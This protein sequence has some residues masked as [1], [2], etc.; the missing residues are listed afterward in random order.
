MISV[1]DILKILDKAPI[2]KTLTQTPK[3]IDALEARVA[4]LEASEQN[5]TQTPGQPCPACGDHALRRTSK[6]ISESP[7]DELGAHDEVWTCKSCGEADMRMH[8]R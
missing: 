8:V 1:S 7:W 5:P 6:T 3:R 4:T 2:W